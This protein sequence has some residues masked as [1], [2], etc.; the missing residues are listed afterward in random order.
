MMSELKSSSVFRKSRDGAC[1]QA[2]R[3]P[4]Y[5]RRDLVT[6]VCAERENLSSR[7]KEKTSSKRHCKRESIEAWHG[8]GTSRSSVEALVMSV[9]RRG[10]VI[11]L[12]LEGNYR[13]QSAQEVQKR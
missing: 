11:G 6:G 10:S 4:V 2:L 5:R 12:S 7:W 13:H 1:I 8:G 3:H 9:E